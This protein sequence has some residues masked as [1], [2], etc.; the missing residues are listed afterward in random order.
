MPC[1]NERGDVGS[2]DE[3]NHV[4]IAMAATC[5]GLVPVTGNNAADHND[6]T[7]D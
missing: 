6:A 3:C 1:L 2:K 4:I 5:M 7:A